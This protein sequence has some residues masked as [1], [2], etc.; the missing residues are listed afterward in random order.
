[1][2]KCFM[3]LAAVL[4]TISMSAANLTGKRI[5]VNP[6]HGSFGKNDR[7][8]PTISYPNL[9]LTG[10]PDTCGFYES[11]T[12]LQKAWYLGQKLKSAGATVLHSHTECGPWPY[13]KVNGDYPDYTWE[14]YSARADFEKYNRSLVEITEEV[15]ANNIDFFIS[16]HSNSATDGATTNYPIMLYRGPDDY[17]SANAADGLEY[18]TGSYEKAAACY[19]ERCKVMQAGI[20]VTSNN[21]TVIRGDWS[22]YG[23]PSNRTHANGKTYK[24]YLGVLKHGASGFLSEGYFHTYQ[25]ARHRALNY[26]YCHME[27]LDYY[28]GIVNYYGADKET[29]GYIVGTIKDKNNKMDN[30]LFTYAQG[31]N[32][33][34]VPCNGAK[35][36]LKKGGVEVARYTVDNN[37]NGLFIFK[38][39]T[40]GDDY[41]L[42]ANYDGYH[43]Y[44]TVLSIQANETTYPMIYLGDPMIYFGDTEQPPIVQQSA[45][46]HISAYNLNVMAEGNNYVFT[47]DA[48]ANAKSANLIFYAGDAEVGK[49]PATVVK[50]ENTIAIA[51]SELPGTRGQELTW[52][53]ELEGDAIANFGIIAS[54]SSL[55]ESSTSRLFNAVNTNPESDN[56]GKIY[57]MHR[58]GSSSS[59]NATKSGLWEYDYNCAKLNTEVYKGG[60]EKFGNPTRISIDNEGYLYLADWND[61]TSGI[62]IASTEDLTQPFTQFF[63]G[64][65]EGNGAF[66]NSGVYTGSSTPGCYVYGEGKDTKLYVYNEDEKGTLPANGIAIY[67]IGQTNGSIKHQW[68]TAPSAVYM[69]TGQGNSEGN[70]WATSHG[71]FVSQVRTSGNNNETATSLKFYD[72]N[73]SEQLSSASN[74]YKNIITGSD[75]GG[76]VVSADESVLVFNDGDMNFLVFDITWEGDKPVLALRY[77]IQHGISKIRQMNWDYAGNIVCS[78]DAGIHI[79]SLPSDENKILVPAKKSL[80]IKTNNQST[81]VEVKEAYTYATRDNKYSLENNWIVSNIEG[82][83]DANKPGTNDYV[84]G[85]ASKDGIIYFI[86]RETK[87]IVRVNGATGEMLSPI[88]I[89]GNHLFEVQNQSTGE[90]SSAVTFGYQDIHFDNAGN[91]LIGACITAGSQHFMIYEVN[92]NTGA[93]T[94]LISERIWDNPNYD[95]LSIRFDAFGVY[96]DV[97]GNAVVMAANAN[98]QTFDVF[99]WTITNGTAHSGEQINV[100]VNANQSLAAGKTGWGTSPRIFP[101]DESGSL[102]YVDGFNTYPMLCDDGG[103]VIG[104]LIMCST[105]TQIQNDAGNATTLVTGHNGCQ[106]FEVGGEHFLIM[107][108]TNTAST[109]PSAFALYRFANRDLGFESLEPLWFFPN[110]GFGSMTNNTRV[111]VPTVEVNNDTATIYLYVQNNGY[112]SYRFVVDHALEIHEPENVTICYGESYTWSINGTTYTQSGTYTATTSN[113]TYTLNLTVMPETKIMEES[114]TINEEELPYVWRNQQCYSA[115]T[116]YESVAFTHYPSCDSVTY[117]LHL[118]TE[119]PNKCGDYLYWHYS[120]NTMTIT[121]SGA[122]YDNPDQLS[123]RQEPWYPARVSHVLLPDGIT[124][125]GN[126]AFADCANLTHIDI[127]NSVTSLGNGAFSWTGLQSVTIPASVT[128][129]GEQVFETCNDLRT[130]LYDGNPTTINNQTIH[131]FIGCVHLD[132][133]ITPAALWH[134]TTANQAIE[135]RYG[136]PNRA[137]YIEVT[138]GELTK[139]AMTYIAKNS[140]TMQVLDLTAATNTTLPLGALMNSYRL[141][142]LYLPE[143]IETVPE[144]LAEG[145]YSLTEIIIPASVTE[146]GNYAFAGCTNVWQMTVDAVV[147]PTVYAETFKDIDRNI[148][149][150]VPTGSEEAYRQA[151]YWQEFFIEDTNSPSPIT[152]CRKL[153][154]EDQILI[155]RNGQT[156]TMMGQL[157]TI[158]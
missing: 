146:I 23:T 58:A 100:T 60:L 109:P 105:G 130:I 73:G 67:K 64:T 41:T 14:D 97:N 117:T 155:L 50:G 37:Y 76:Y 12:N 134:C 56:F 39:L 123:Y 150:I 71:F 26:D 25:P 147:P 69:L 138:D 15:E 86:N 10:M 17:A 156:Y 28:R 66:N 103:N 75:A 131:P 33:Q 122:M 79:V 46:P 83:F 32:D 38:D 145:C 113:G 5:Y 36:V 77:T 70:V 21:E 143:Q 80:S 127:P 59:A 106:E 137:H 74:L 125:I 82:N 9:P 68:Q 102:F 47:F 118:T 72:N 99:R 35:V 63:A 18:V 112:A 30:S 34:W 90:W 53:V 11:N 140:G 8:M 110:E 98:S 29:V 129:I 101:Q 107:A 115:G 141:S 6:G 136:V 20:D 104:D 95:Q 27:G 84:R 142:T 139:Q 49:V 114:I 116:Y 93:A 85:M 149:V 43:E 153:L 152:N 1:M 4:L 96:G 22:F 120:N 148:S 62:Y 94:L 124:H 65:R 126:V 144:M 111:A 91:C 128:K 13:A 119:A 158:E 48:N 51:A 31:S 19:T 132:T 121:G 108:A 42:E 135:A 45:I 81:P 57:I 133:I 92:L 52:A 24:G 44:K 157:V 7:P 3:L 89:T 40:P 154:R 54:D 87:S 151:A 2:K 16:I 55:I 61:G 78:G 88:Q